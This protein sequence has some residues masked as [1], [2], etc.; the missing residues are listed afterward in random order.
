VKRPSK[1]DPKA[2]LMAMPASLTPRFTVPSMICG[3]R[4]ISCACDMFA[5]RRT[6]VSD[7]CV[8]RTGGMEARESG[9]MCSFIRS[10][11]FWLSAS[12]MY[13][14]PST[15]VKR[16]TSSSISAIC[17][18]YFGETNEPTMIV[19][20]PVCERASSRRTLS[21]TE[22]PADSI[23]MPSRMTSSVMWTRG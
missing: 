6:N 8:K 4:S 2:A 23:C 10:R 7:R 17:G 14:T 19:F 20:S 11:P 18:V 21:S 16:R 1:F 3:Q 9:G 13:F 12:A 15:G 22:M 5:L